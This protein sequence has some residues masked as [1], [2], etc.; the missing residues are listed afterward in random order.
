M[1]LNYLIISKIYILF[2]CHY[3]NLMIN[4]QQCGNL[5]KIMGIIIYFYSL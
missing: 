4:F 3:G 5:W 1:P 2:M